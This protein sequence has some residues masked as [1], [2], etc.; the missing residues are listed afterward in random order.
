VAGTAKESPN[1]RIYERD[2]D[3]SL[4]APRWWQEY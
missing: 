2:Q 3:G 1:R 4:L